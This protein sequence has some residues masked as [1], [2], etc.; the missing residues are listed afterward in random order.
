MKLT[1]S[2]LKEMIKEE[3]LTERNEEHFKKSVE[4]VYQDIDRL[5]KT[6]NTTDYK[7]SK[8][9][10]K[11]IH[12]TKQL[13]LK[14]HMALDGITWN[15]PREGVSEQKLNE[16]ETYQLNQQLV[17]ELPDIFQHQLKRLGGT[18]AYMDK[19][20]SRGFSKILQSYLKAIKKLA[21]KF[22]NDVKKVK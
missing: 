14:L 5:I 22:G 4:M 3:L 8:N 15:V 20:D 17:D 1:K 9:A 2:K 19:Q 11:F 10:K 18:Q 16:M 13:K 7:K 6:F 12:T 21:A